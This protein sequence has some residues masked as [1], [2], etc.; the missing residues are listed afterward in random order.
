VDL[1]E[2]RGPCRAI[3]VQAN[4]AHCVEADAPR[5]LLIADAPRAI[6]PLAGR[7]H[8]LLRVVAFIFCKQLSLRAR[9]MSKLRVDVGSG[10]R[11]EVTVGQN[12]TL[13]YVLEEVCKRRK[14]DPATHDLRHQRKVCDRSTTVRFAGLTS[15]A[16]LELVSSQGK[17]GHGECT[18]ALQV[19]G[20]GG[21]RPT[22]KLH[23]SVTV[24]EAIKQLAPE[25]PSA[26]CVVYMGRAVSGAGLETTTLLNLGISK[27]TS[28]LLRLSQVYASD[29]LSSPLASKPHVA[30]PLPSCG[31]APARLPQVSF[32]A[33]NQPT[34]LFVACH[35]PLT[36]AAPHPPTGTG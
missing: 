16:M 1:P 29:R 32:L 31:W 14:L 33:R 15:N 8:H 36:P 19:E 7:S 10:R 3:S 13:G 6:S 28:A 18:I 30:A 12:T 11:E 17:S 2:R 26:P 4:R 25:A 23:T 21:A 35:S 5:R 9:R 27:G 24:L 22:A 34:L 20:S